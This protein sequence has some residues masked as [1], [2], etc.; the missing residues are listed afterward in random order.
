MIFLIW[1]IFYGLLLVLLRRHISWLIS[2]FWLM[3]T[4]FFTAWNSTLPDF[5]A[6]FGEDWTFNG[7]AYPAI[8]VD[9]QVNM[10][11]VMKGGTYEDVTVTVYIRTD[12]F[13]S[14]GVAQD[15][16]VTIRGQD[17]AVL[18]IEQEGDECR[19]LICGSPQIDVWGK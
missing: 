12:I 11:R 5:E 1:R 16:T 6:E 14:S 17:F 8:A 2:G 19:I 10:T 13:N 9:K 15:Q 7:V 4:D 18:Q 3:V